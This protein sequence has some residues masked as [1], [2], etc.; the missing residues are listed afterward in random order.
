MIW[1]YL[2]VFLEQFVAHFFYHFPFQILNGLF[3]ICSCKKSHKLLRKSQNY[4]SKIFRLNTVS[5]SQL[6]LPP[7]HRIEANSWNVPVLNCCNRNWQ[8]NE[9]FNIFVDRELMYF[10]LR[11]YFKLL[12]SWPLTLVYKIVQLVLIHYTE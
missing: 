10:I 9:N 7:S 12:F 8:N 1:S 4:I 6:T 3:G 11:S 2:F 5:Q